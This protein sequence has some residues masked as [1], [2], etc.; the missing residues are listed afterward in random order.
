MGG[1]GWYS[2]HQ[3]PIAWLGMEDG[4]VRF[5]PL[6]PQAEGDMAAQVVPTRTVPTTLVTHCDGCKN[7]QYLNQL[8]LPARPGPTL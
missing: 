7:G 8:Y 2:G 6:Q 5:V 3:S 1:G 4:R